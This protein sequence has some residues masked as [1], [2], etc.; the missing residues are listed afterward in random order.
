MKRIYALGLFLTMLLGFGFNAKAYTVTLQWATPGSVKIATPW[1]NYVDIPIG[2]TSMNVEQEE[3]WTSIYVTSADGYILNGATCDGENLNVGQ[4][5]NQECITI[6]KNYDGKTVIIDCSKPKRNDAIDIYVENG[7]STL[8]VTSFT[9][10]TLSL[11]QGENTIP[12]NPDADNPLT[13]T[14]AGQEEIY[15]IALNNVQYAYNEAED[16]WEPEAIK[17]WS[18]TAA[19]YQITL[20]AGDE[21]YLEPLAPG[22]AEKK[23]CN[24]TIDYGTNMEGCLSNIMDHSTNH[25][26]LPDEYEGGVITGIEN[27]IEGAELTLNFLSEDFTI[28]KLTLNGT[29]ITSQLTNEGDNVK[30]YANITVDKENTVLKIEGQASVWADVV[31]TGYVSIPEGLQLGLSMDADDLSYTVVGDCGGQTYGVLTMPEGSKEIKVTVSEKNNHG[32][33]T[34]YFQPKEGYFISVCY[35]GTPNDSD[36]KGTKMVNAAIGKD[37]DKSFYMIIDK[38]DPEYTANMNVHVTGYPDVTYLTSSKTY[39][40]QNDNPAQKKITLQPGESTIT[41]IPNYDNPF[42]LSLNQNQSAK[43]YLD[44]AEVS[45][46]ANSD[47]NQTDYLLPLYAPAAGE[48]SDIHSDVQVYFTGS[49]AMATATLN[50]ENNATAEFYYSPVMHPVN[51]ESLPVIQGTVMTVKPTSANAVVVYKGVAQTLDS[52]GEFQF[53]TSSTAADNTVTVTGPK[54]IG[55]VGTVPSNGSTLKSLSQFTLLIPIKVDEEELNMQPD[56]EKLAGLT[57]TTRQNEVV[58]TV[59][60]LGEG[61]M[62]EDGNMTCP[63]ILNKTITA[64]GT[65]YINVPAG[66]FAQMDGEQVVPGG[67]ITAAYSGRLKVDPNFTVGVELSFAN[68][69]SKIS[70]TED[71]GTIYIL[72]PDATSATVN[73][74]LLEPA[75]LTEQSN[76]AD[77]YEETGNIEIIETQS[78]AATGVTAAITFDPAPTKKA[79]YSLSIKEDAIRLD[80]GNPSP[81]I[82]NEYNTDVLTGIFEIFADEDGNVTV[83]TIDGKAVLKNAPAESLRTLDKGLYIINGKKTLVK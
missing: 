57:V 80:G 5:Y 2:A 9:G 70:K 73:Y 78:R 20:A 66:A 63:I 52:N 75:T 76:A 31:Y 49:P 41:F 65:Y 71:L 1:G 62:T 22:T 82:T 54:S 74:S 50:L 53:T 25:M 23:L 81:A 29:D 42:T 48:T 64:E 45:G 30:Q 15:K 68:G 61:G 7:L 13:V 35:V 51:G 34:F 16:K 37:D 39:S 44:G 4:I 43:I 21:L 27:V 77:K 83:F 47:T 40:E 56:M 46:S 55:I 8:T 33:G 79:I 36:T 14:V 32:H 69:E 19:E 59:E 18:N 3:S 6:N 38:L 28:T 10:E 24:L 58:A 72:F 60:E 26:Y 67:Y 11:K 17:K 12:F